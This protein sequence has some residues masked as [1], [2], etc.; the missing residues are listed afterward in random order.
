MRTDARLIA[1]RQSRNELVGARG[2]SGLDDIR[3]RRLRA[4]V[5]DILEYCA[6]D[7]LA[8]LT[9]KSDARAPP[10]GI[11]RPDVPLAQADLTRLRLEQPAKVSV[12][13]SVPS[14][15]TQREW[16]VMKVSPQRESK[17]S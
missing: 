13:A 15:G 3:S 8:V 16:V 6:G 9:G 1:V 12:R 5:S 2:T 17:W 7:E 4:R 10:A 11:E 14:G